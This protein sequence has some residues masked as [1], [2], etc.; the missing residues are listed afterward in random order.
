MYLRHFELS[1]SITVCACMW[2]PFSGFKFLL[3]A[4][5]RAQKIV[6]DVEIISNASKKKVLYESKRRP[7]FA[8]TI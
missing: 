6:R 3:P 5:K 8:S 1:C 2:I 4:L 7:Q